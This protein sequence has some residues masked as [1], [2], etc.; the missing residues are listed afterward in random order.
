MNNTFN[1]S[2]RQ[3][4]REASATFKAHWKF[5]VG[6]ALITVLINIV[7]GDN[8][9]W[10]ISVVLMIAAYIW[11]IVWFKISLA[12]ARN[13]HS[14][15]MF[16][17]LKDLLPTW[18]EVLYLVGIALL[19]GLIVLCGL[20]LLIIPGIY[21]GIRLSLA[22]Y[23]YLDRHETVQKSLRY[24]WNITK[25]KF[26]TVLLTSIVV[27]ALYVLGVFALGIGLFIAYPLASIL[28]AR[29]YYALSDDF[30]KKEAVVV[31]PVE[32]PADLPEVAT[33]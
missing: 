11:S 18:T 13:D 4:L 29:L 24:S 16:T 19:G 12:A 26:W 6:V 14:K 2:I 3:A 30:N 25:G 1:F 22:N 10:V 7:G 27:V 28:M 23:A 20:I 15:L 31:Q 5:F 17:S 9:P 33:A 21:V 8:I 32:I